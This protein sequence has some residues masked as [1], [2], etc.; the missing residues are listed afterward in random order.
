MATVLGVMLEQVLTT[1]LNAHGPGMVP[2][3][4]LMEV[5]MQVLEAVLEAAEKHPS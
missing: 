5:L 1:V 2:G 3:V 4:T